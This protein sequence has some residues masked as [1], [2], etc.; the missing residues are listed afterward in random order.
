MKQSKYASQRKEVAFRLKVIEFHNFFGR[1]APLEA[2]LVSV[3][4]LSSRS[5]RDFWSKFKAW[6]YI[7]FGVYLL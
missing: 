5:G 3:K 4:L 6:E 7:A 1:E 2:S